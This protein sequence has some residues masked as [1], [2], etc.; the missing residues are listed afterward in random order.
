MSEHPTERC[1]HCGQRIL[2]ESDHRGPTAQ[3]THVL[4]DTVRDTLGPM[5][6]A[7][8]VAVVFAVTVLLIAGPG[9]FIYH[10][11][12]G[13]ALGGVLCLALAAALLLAR[14]SAAPRRRRR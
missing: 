9:H 12:V 3:E 11:T 4:R 14:R 1:P 10:R 8:T 7:R 5:R 6:D 13:A 2:A